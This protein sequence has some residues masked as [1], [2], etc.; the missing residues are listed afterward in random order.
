[1]KRYRSNVTVYGRG[2]QGLR[3][4]PTPRRGGAAH[5][6]SERKHDLDHARGLRVRHLK[7]LGKLCQREAVRDERL[8][9]HLRARTVWGVGVCGEEGGESA[10]RGSQP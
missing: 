2:L 3:L 4:L 1:M 7:A 10:S 6:L 9:V 5:R 8:D